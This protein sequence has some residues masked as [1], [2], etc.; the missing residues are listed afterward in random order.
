VGELARNLKAVVGVARTLYGYR[1]VVT[2]VYQIATSL[3]RAIAPPALPG[4]TQPNPLRFVR[5]ANANESEC[6]SS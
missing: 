2:S 4:R 5:D 3:A 6:S 1:P